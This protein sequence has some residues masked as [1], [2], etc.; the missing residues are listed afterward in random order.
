MPVSFS[1]IS[2]PYEL[3]DR[4]LTKASTQIDVGDAMKEDTG[5][6][7]ATSG[8]KVLAVAL[9]EKSSAVAAQTPIQYMLVYPGRTKF[10][11]TRESGTLT[12]AEEK[13]F[14]DLA[15]ADGFAGDVSTN[16]DLFIYARLDADSAIVQFADPAS[17]NATN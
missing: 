10:F 1:K 4:W 12:Q 7:P 15:S 14:L 13:T 11:G 17:L 2:G 8:A 5:L 9:E 3:D 16:D 6:A